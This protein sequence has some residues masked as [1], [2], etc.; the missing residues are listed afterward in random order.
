MEFV[1][2]RLINRGQN[3]RKRQAI[4]GAAQAREAAA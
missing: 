1:M 2:R 4:A 3:R